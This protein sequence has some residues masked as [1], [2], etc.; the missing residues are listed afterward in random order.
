MGYTASTQENVDFRKAAV[1]NQFSKR[2]R[3]K[4]EIVIRVNIF[5]AR[6]GNKKCTN[7]ISIGNSDNKFCLRIILANPQ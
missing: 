1:R 7:K 5:V 4:I 2:Y 6:H 3:G